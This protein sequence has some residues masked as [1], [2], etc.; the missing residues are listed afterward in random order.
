MPPSTPR[1]THS[2]SSGSTEG[3]RK[4]YSL[5]IEF[6][7]D[8]DDDF[9]EQGHATVE[10]QRRRSTPAASAVRSRATTGPDHSRESGRRPRHTTTNS[11]TEAV[12]GVEGNRNGSSMPVQPPLVERSRHTGTTRPRAPQTSAYGDEAF[13]TA[14]ETQLSQAFDGMSMRDPPEGVDLSERFARQMSMGN[15][16]HT[17]G[18]P[19]SY[20]NAATQTA[21][22]RHSGFNP[23]YRPAAPV[24]PFMRSTD[25]DEAH[26]SSAIEEAYNNG[27]F[28]GQ[29]SATMHSYNSQRDTQPPIQHRSPSPSPLPTRSRSIYER[30]S[31]GRQHREQ[32]QPQSRGLR[33][34]FPFAWG[35]ARER[36]PSPSPPPRSRN[37]GRDP[38]HRR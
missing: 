10:R 2:R 23:L 13:F 30:E 19:N 22:S 33:S 31:T 21:T 34:L 36:A 4:R 5:R 27:F 17:R 11:S 26:R 1:E 16:E 3:R 12:V 6:L 29:R 38:R 8:D 7:D 37:S 25:Q 15:T 32:P 28:A 24:P 14:V 20:M 35:A 9:F 18:H